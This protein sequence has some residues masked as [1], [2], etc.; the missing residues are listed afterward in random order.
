MESEQ[1]RLQRFIDSKGQF[2]L[3]VSAVP[4]EV[5]EDRWYSAVWSRVRNIYPVSFNM[6]H[7]VAVRE[8]YS[9]SMRMGAQKNSQAPITDRTKVILSGSS[10]LRDGGTDTNT[11]LGRGIQGT[12]RHQFSPR[13]SFQVGRT[14]CFCY[15]MLRD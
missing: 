8:L 7:T 6:K 10:S 11:I 5:S 12:V 15:Q 13:S 3:T 9:I 1:L 4:G 14:L 2:T